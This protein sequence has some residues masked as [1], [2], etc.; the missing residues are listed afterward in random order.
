VWTNDNK[1]EAALPTSTPGRT[2]EPVFSDKRAPELAKDAAE[3]TK[4]SPCFSKTEDFPSDNLEQLLNIP[5]IK[6]KSDLNINQRIL[7]NTYIFF[8]KVFTF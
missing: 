5:K 1:P 7:L 4:R 2:P 8:T 3:E 6:H